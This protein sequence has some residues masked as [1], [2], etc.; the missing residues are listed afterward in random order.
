MDSENLIKNKI[1]VCITIDTEFSIGGAFG[2]PTKNTPVGLQ[3]V[4]CNIKNKSHGLG[5]I[6]D[7]F[8]R[9]EIEATF[10]VEA[11]N[12]A[13]FGS[14]PMQEIVNQI[15]KS[16]QN[17]ELHLHPVWQ[18]IFTQDNW[19]SRIKELQPNDSILTRTTEELDDLI[20]T[21]IENLTQWSGQKPNALR[22]GNL[23]CNTI[24]YDMMAKHD[25]N[26]SSNISLGTYFPPEEELQIASGSQKIG[27]ITEFPVTSYKGIQIGNKQET[28]ALTIIGSSFS[29]MKY[30]LNYAW[31]QR[32]SPIVFLTHPF[33]YI[34]HYDDQL[35]NGK[36]NKL[37]Q[38]R[39][40]NLCQYLYENDDKYRAT[41]INEISNYDIGNN[42]Q[43]IKPPFSLGIKR[44]VE[45]K[46]SENIG[47]L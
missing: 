10:F 23:H 30:I 21:G 11:L 17:V 40:S 31:E 41:A 4:Y 33:E 43:I 1:D 36:P 47:Y 24:V 7:C 8:K 6:L 35:N 15:L 44:I 14:K 18:Q 25:M 29:E 38:N 9:Y 3:N 45:N 46:L 20:S 13:Y 27:Q 32:I 42:S 19:Q 5:F 37:T 16:K 34:K 26:I 12:K 28:K 39:L 22:T 2:D